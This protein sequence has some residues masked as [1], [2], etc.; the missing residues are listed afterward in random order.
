MDLGIFFPRYEAHSC[1]VILQR[2]E[3]LQLTMADNAEEDVLLRRLFVLVAEIIWNFLD[4]LLEVPHVL[5]WLVDVN[6]ITQVAN[7]H[8]A[9]HLYV[10]ALGWIH[11]ALLSHGR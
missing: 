8:D 9:R 4:P 2:S 5:R 3:V 6:I 1:D 11:N 7:L 10:D